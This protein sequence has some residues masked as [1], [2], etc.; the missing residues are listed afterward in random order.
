[1]KTLK[2]IRESNVSA[3][4]GVRG[5]GDMSGTPATTDDVENSHIERVTQGAIEYSQAVKDYI[6]NTTNGIYT[7][8]D[9]NWW[10]KPG[11][12]KSITLLGT[13]TT[14][15]KT[16][17]KLS[18]EMTTGGVAG[19]GSPA[20]EGKPS[21]WSEPGVLLTARE[22]HKKRARKTFTNMLRRK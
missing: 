6:N 2:N 13:P 12:V 3:G 4:F 15:T 21:N 18:E 16:T 14:K 10:A 20:P 8:N 22:K 19:I 9:T 7:F 5:F 17:T 1:M 11:S